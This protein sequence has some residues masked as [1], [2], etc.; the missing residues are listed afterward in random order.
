M[1]FLVMDF[2]TTNREAELLHKLVRSGKI[3]G[4]AQRRLRVILERSV[5]GNRR[6]V[7]AGTY[8]FSL[9]FVDRWYRRWI[10]S[11]EVRFQWAEAHPSVVSNDRLYGDFLVSI[12]EDRPRSGV[13]AKFGPEVREKIIALAL[14]YPPDLGLPFERWSHYLLSLEVVKRGIAP[15]ISSTRVGDFLKGAPLATSP[16]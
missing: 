6:V 4:S 3:R 9:P 12:V 2:T 1:L 5:R 14:T 7:T 8:G 16:M 15:Q 13:P 11:Q 10:A